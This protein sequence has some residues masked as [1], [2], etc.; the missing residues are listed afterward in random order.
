MRIVRSGVEGLDIRV[1]RA[2]QMQRVRASFSRRTSHAQ[3]TVHRFRDAFRHRQCN[4]LGDLKPP[5][6]HQLRRAE[7]RRVHGELRENLQRQ[8]SSSDAVRREILF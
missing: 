3:V 5:E 4:P 1:L 8:A 6:P 7:P 2:R